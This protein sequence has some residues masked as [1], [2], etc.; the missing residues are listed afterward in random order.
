MGVA[1]NGAHSEHRGWHDHTKEK[2][3]FPVRS[4]LGELIKLGTGLGYFLRQRF[5][6]VADR[7]GLHF[8]IVLQRYGV[9]LPQ[10]I[11][12]VQKLLPR[13]YGFDVF[14]QR[15]GLCFHAFEA[16]FRCSTR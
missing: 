13:F 15:G 2:N 10:R 1:V 4:G 7:R 11:S 5:A 3:E 8:P 16:G 12:E 14:L 6:I 9:I